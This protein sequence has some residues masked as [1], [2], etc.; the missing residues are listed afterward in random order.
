MDNV[1]A[2]VETITPETAREYLKF[3]TVNRPFNKITV[4]YYADQMKKGQWL[5]NGEAICFADGGVL[6]NGQHRLN[7]VIKAGVP[8][9]TLV[10]RGV[11]QQSFIT[12]DNG[13]S[14]T[15]ADVLSLSEVPNAN[16][17]ASIIKKYLL[18]KQ[19][20]SVLKS[21]NNVSSSKTYKISK[22]DMF[23]CYKSDSEN[24]QKA[25]LFAMQCTKKL[26]I[27]K[28]TEIGS[29]Y[30]YLVNVKKHPQEFV[31]SFFRMLFFN[32]NVNNSTI[33]GYRDK[34]VQSKINSGMKMSSKYKE[35]LFN[36]TW[37]AYVTGKEL[38]MLSWNEA[39]EGKI[40]LI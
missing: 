10:V 17:V 12:F 15:M 28:A 3:N 24:I 16:Y 4:D 36:K 22:Q 34:C 13:R 19:G 5:L 27:M 31:E 33:N 29:I 20:Y 35:S 37:N 38:K 7:A 18:I 1:K 25:T 32:E 26:N 9:Q 11:S 14:R 40:E 30:L 2:Q 6:I 23:E 39:K 21:G 8:I